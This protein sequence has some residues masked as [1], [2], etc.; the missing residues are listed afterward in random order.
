MPTRAVPARFLVA[1][2]LAGE[3][4]ELVRA[5]AEAVENQL[6]RGSV[7]LDEWFEHYIAGDDADLKLQE[8]YGRRCELAVVCV[9]ER[10]GSKPWTQAEHQAIRARNMKCSA[11]AEKRES[12]AILPIRVGDG[13]VEG[14][15]FN[16]IVP[17]VRGRS[18]AASADLI[19]ARLHLLRPDLSAVAAGA[20]PGPAWPETPPA[21]SWPMA[22]HSGAREAFAQLLTSEVLWRLLRI[23]GVSETGKSHITRQM[24]ANVLPIADIACGRFDFKGTTDMDREVRAFV[25]NL[26]VTAPPS[27]PRLYERFDQVLDALRQRAQPTLL[28]FDTYEMAGEAQEWVEKSLLQS[29]IRET[30]LRV[31]IAGQQV[32]DASG[33]VWAAVA[34]PSVQLEPP[35]PAD[36]YDYGKRHRPNLELAQVETACYLARGKASLLAQMLGPAA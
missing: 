6:G 13:E 10:Y 33:S 12:D 18:A 20:P 26:G 21:L 35:P 9:S 25:Q 4:R 34:C 29:L 31:V 24:L 14:I 15:L 8:I 2:S 5:I 28:I 1:F 16:A 22:N 36:W 27:T 7:F 30:W 3:Q 32:P 23:R 11:A 19:I 17:D